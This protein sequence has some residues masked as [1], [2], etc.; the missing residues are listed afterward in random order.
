MFRILTELILFA[1]PLGSVWINHGISV[2]FSLLVLIS[3]LGIVLLRNEDLS[4]KKDEVTLMLLFGAFFLCS[5]ISWW[6]HGM[7]DSGLKNIGKHL[8]FLFL[9]PVYVLVRRVNP[10]TDFLWYGVVFGSIILLL[11]AVFAD[12]PYGLDRASGAVNPILFGDISLILGFISFAARDAFKE[13]SPVIRLLP[14]VALVCAVAASILSGSRGSWIAIPG[15]LMVMFFAYGKMRS[16]RYNVTILFVACVLPIVIYVIPATGVKDRFNFAVSDIESYQSGSSEQTSLGIRFESWKAAY[17]MAADNPIFGVGI[18]RYHQEANMLIDKGI[19][20]DSAVVYNHTHND[21]F[22]QLA[23]NGIIGLIILVLLFVYPLI[24][25]YRNFFSSDYQVKS[26]A[27]SGIFL[28]VAFIH[29]SLSETLM[30]RSASV[31]VYGFFVIVL[32]AL[33]NNYKAEES[34]E[35]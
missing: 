4:L 16:V 6:W 23:V 32:V 14:I 21:F 18:G 8:R 35:N 7:D 17:Y 1:L 20:S 5:L 2:P 26:L 9:I 34:I 28:V 33:M 24:L 15:L 19:V 25:F 3:L 31:S 10:R 27:V 22:Y 11:V 13:K 12:R 30:I 29:F